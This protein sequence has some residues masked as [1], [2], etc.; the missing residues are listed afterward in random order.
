MIEVFHKILKSGCRAEEA[1]LRTA[2]RLV[3]LIAV[4]CIMSWRIFW[5]TM[6]TRAAPNAPPEAALTTLEVRILHRLLP[7]KGAI[8]RHREPLGSYLTKIAKL[9]GYLARKKDPPPGNIVMWR[10]LSRL[11]DIKLGVTFGYRTCG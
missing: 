2:E 11:T 6:L 7:D 5:M 4:F 10:G 3:K 1:K 9:G 8:R